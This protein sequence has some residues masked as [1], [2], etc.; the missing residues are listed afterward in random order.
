MKSFIVAAIA[1]A[2]AFGIAGA[3]APTGPKPPKPFDFSGKW[4]SNQGLMVLNQ[5]ADTA[6][7]T[8]ATN[9]GRVMLTVKG[10]VANGWWTQSASGQRCQK[11]KQGSH[12]YG[13]AQLIAQADG[14]SFNGEWAYCDHKLGDGGGSWTGKRK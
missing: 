2:L 13:R 10:D 4:D 3:K 6:S 11:V 1:G 7:G 8:Y 5:K 9:D 14:K 12:Y